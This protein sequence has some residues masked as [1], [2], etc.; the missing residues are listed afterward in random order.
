MRADIALHLYDETPE[1]Y[2]RIVRHTETDDGACLVIASGDDTYRRDKLRVHD[3]DP[4]ALC[5]IIDECAEAWEKLTGRTLLVG[6][7]DAA[8]V[9]GTEVRDLLEQAMASADKW[10]AE[11]WAEA[12]AVV[13]AALP[14]LLQDRP[15]TESDDD[16]EPI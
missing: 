10:R 1:I 2:T 16:D 14:A 5:C 11:A 3:L 13:V 9:P 6:D 7:V 12:L 8:P 15:D 4:E